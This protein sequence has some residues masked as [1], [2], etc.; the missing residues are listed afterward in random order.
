M[1]FPKLNIDEYILLGYDDWAMQ[2]GNPILTKGGN[3]HD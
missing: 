1:Q 3:H 2:F